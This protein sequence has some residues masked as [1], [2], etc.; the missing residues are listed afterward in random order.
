ML[1]A[2]LTMLAVGLLLPALIIVV[3]TVTHKRLQRKRELLGC[4]GA[5]HPID[6]ES[7]RGINERLQE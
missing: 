1:V 7:I 5:K 2:L 3:A 6:P 4:G